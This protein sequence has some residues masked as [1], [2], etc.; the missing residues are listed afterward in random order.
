MIKLNYC[1]YK[2]LHKYYIKIS[3]MQSNFTILTDTFN[4]RNCKFFIEA[5]HHALT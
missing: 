1:M 3:T 2:K 4:F 5:I